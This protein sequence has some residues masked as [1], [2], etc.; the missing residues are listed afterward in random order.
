MQTIELG[1]DVSPICCDPSRRTGLARSSF[2][3]MKSLT[4]KTSITV[5]AI[6]SGSVAAN[7][8]VARFV[9]STDLAVKLAANPN[10]LE[11][12][13]A[14][15]TYFQ[16]GLGKW[17]GRTLNL[18]RDPLR[19][20]CDD[21]FDVVHSTYARLGRRLRKAG[22]PCI[23]TVHDL[24]PLVLS[25]DV[26]PPGQIGVTRRI[27]NSIRPTDWV[28][29]PSESSKQ[30]AL[31]A[32]KLPADR[33]FVIPWGV[34]PDVF[35][36]EENCDIMLPE[37]LHGKDFLMTV[38]SLAP[39]KNIPFLI[40]CFAKACESKSND[41]GTLV[42]V[43]ST[44]PAVREHFLQGIPSSVQSRIL[45]TGYLDDNAIRALYTKTQAFLFPSLYEG[46]GFPA[47][48]AMACGSP[49]ICSN[50]GSL[51]EIPGIFPGGLSPSDTDSWVDAIRV[52][53]TSERQTP[54]VHSLDVASRFDWGIT[55]DR[56][57][58]VY[59]HVIGVS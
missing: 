29:C 22:A 7:L 25:E 42:I 48:E 13:V 17:V 52:A 9:H 23:L 43:G 3:L 15:N 32:T 44:G 24:I 5:T 18:A 14:R 55:A 37:S 12:L 34:D 10:R 31:Q 8:E 38:G 33:C 58:D 19:D 54:D 30:D 35:Y 51:K 26:S 46:F 27:I 36:P 21:R 4:D 41:I 53:L 49:V 56:H 16:H 47:I 20:V 6:G 57:L 50:G 11:T 2:L 40:K 39:H 1:L 45:F 28:I 59:R